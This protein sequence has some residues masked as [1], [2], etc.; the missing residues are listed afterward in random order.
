MNENIDL[1]KILKDC[2]KGFKLYS[3]SFGEV[4]FEGISGDVYPITLSYTGREAL[5]SFTK[6]GFYYDN[7][8][9][10]CLLFPSKEQRDWEKFTAPWYKKEKFDPKTLQPFDKV[11]ARDYLHGKWTCGFFSHIVIFDN[12]YMYNIGEVLYKMCISYN[13]E[14][15][16]LVGTT[17][18]APDYYKYWE[19]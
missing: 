18:E 13:E 4:V 10:E 1:T 7:P 11:L 15:K 16:H 8:D 2:P 14:T 17:E 5:V 3:P 9:T 12:T 6:E 19:D